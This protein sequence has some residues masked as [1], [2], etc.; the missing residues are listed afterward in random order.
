MIDLISRRGLLIDGVYRFSLLLLI[1]FLSCAALFHWIGPLCGEYDFAGSLIIVRDEMLRGGLLLVM[2]LMGALMLIQSNRVLF[3]L[4]RDRLRWWFFWVVF[5]AGIFLELLRFSFAFPVCGEISMFLFFLSL[6]QLFGWWRVLGGGAI[7]VLGYLLVG[8]AFTVLKASVFLRGVAYDRALSAVDVFFVGGVLNRDFVMWVQNHELAMI[9][10]D[11][12]YVQF[13]S[14]VFFNVLACVYVGGR[15][16]L[17]AYGVALVCCYFFAVV[18]YILLP[19]Y[20][21]FVAASADYQHGWADGPWRVAEIQRAIVSNTYAVRDC[22]EGK[23]RPFAYVAAMPSLHVAVPGLGVAMMWGRWRP[24]ALL[25]IPLVATAFAAL[26]TGMH[27]G[28]DV[29]AGG[30]LAAACARAAR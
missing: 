9:F 12:V 18:V 3:K 4:R 26:A 20:G 6:S 24:F 7:I 5:F 8:Y 16:M 30:M 25:S 15:R 17:R 2:L 1:V 27:Y 22:A 11:E 21:P 29:V 13:F 28:I 10:A 14:L 23:I 19:A